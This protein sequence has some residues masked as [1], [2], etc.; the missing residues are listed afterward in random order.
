VR[1]ALVERGLDGTAITAEG[2]GEQQ[3][4]LIAGVE[5]KLASRRVEFRIQTTP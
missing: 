1:E 5:D 4:V 2:F 3:P